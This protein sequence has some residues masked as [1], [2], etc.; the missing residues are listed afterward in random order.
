M[1]VAVCQLNARADRSANLEVAREL[2]ERAAAGGADLAVLPEF[3]DY[4]GPAD[5]LP[6][7]EGLDGE[8]GWFFAKAARELS[9]WVL[10]GSFHEA[11]P[12]PEHVHNTSMVF[13]R[14][15][16][17]A[18]TYRKIHLYDVEIP[19]RVSYLESASVAPGAVPGA[20]V[21]DSR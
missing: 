12:D 11:G 21:V 2:L 5:G 20:T 16:G 7:P 17:L 18:G 10:A 9:M 8:Y 4:L 15:G 14:S 3:T 13:D 1:R 6:E 19:G